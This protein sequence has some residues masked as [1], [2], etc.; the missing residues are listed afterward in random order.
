MKQHSKAYYVVRSIARAITYLTIG[1]LALLVFYVFY[2]CVWSL[3]G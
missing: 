3:S 2:L 1:Y